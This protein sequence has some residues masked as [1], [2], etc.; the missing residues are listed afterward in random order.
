MFYICI[1]YDMHLNRLDLNLLLVF[2]ELLASRNLTAA[3]ARLN[4]TQP[5]MSHALRRLRSAC[6]DPLFV[7]TARGMEPTPYALSVAGDVAQA[8]EL[9]RAT[10]AR[11]PRFDPA[12]SDR[13]FRI[14]MADIGE[15]VFLPG[16]MA[17]L[18]RV[19]PNMNIT[20]QQIQ[21]DLYR[22]SLQ[23]GLADI[24]LGQLTIAGKGFRQEVLFDD[25]FVCMVRQG[26]PR[27]RRTLTREDFLRES[28]IVVTPPGTGQSVAED[29]L[30][31]A[32]IVRRVALQ[33]PH[34][35]VVPQLLGEGDFIMTLPSRAA[36]AIKGQHRLRVFAPPVALPAIRVGLLWHERNDND[37]AAA[38]LRNTIV[39]LFKAEPKGRD[40]G[41]EAARRGT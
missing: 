30:A 1:M 18:K 40:P 12:T 6:G 36:A 37:T 4:M 3:A 28:H 21:R 13:R 23:T 29:T 5:T 35:L 10:F 2:D 8:L 9:I 34:Y 26:H 20:T 11:N 32:G 17:R 7:R 15:V 41:A 22:E 14:L 16:L 27:V 31:R 19:A 24:A 33:V 38:W 39:D 25:S